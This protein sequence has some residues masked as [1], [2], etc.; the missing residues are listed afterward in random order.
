[1]ELSYCG[2]PAC[3]GH[4]PNGW[5]ELPRDHDLQTRRWR[6]PSGEIVGEAFNR[7]AIELLKSDPEEYLRRTR[8]R[9][10]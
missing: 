5:V 10:T 7:K 6:S 3:E 2:I 9:L 8:R 1:M 4:P